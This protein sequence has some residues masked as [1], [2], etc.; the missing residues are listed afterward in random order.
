MFNNLLKFQTPNNK[1]KFQIHLIQLNINLFKLINSNWANNYN[2]IYFSNTNFLNLVTFEKKKLSLQGY[3]SGSIKTFWHNNSWV[4]ETKTNILIAPKN[5]TFNLFPLYLNTLTINSDT[6]YTI[7]SSFTP[8]FFSNFKG[9]RFINLT[10]VYHRWKH[11]VNLLFNLFYNQSSLLLFSN[12]LLKNEVLSFNWNLLS[13]H[14]NLFQ[15]ATPYFYFK[16]NSYGDQA[17]FVFEKI[18]FMGVEAAFI[19]DT[20]FHYRTSSFLK[21]LNYFLLGLT[22]F[23]SNPWLVHYPIPVASS[24]LFTQ[25]FFLK[26]LAFIKRYSLS[27]YFKGLFSKVNYII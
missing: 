20:K 6:F 1:N 8:L 25:Y 22:S 3:K 18:S 12:K 14:L 26:H 5:S 15:Y 16:N 4:S 9:F 2:W 19:L 24:T 17:H 10:K 13:T 23:N 11:T 7:H 27:L 21:T